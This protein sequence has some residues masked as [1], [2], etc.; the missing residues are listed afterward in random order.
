MQQRNAKLGEAHDIFAM[1]KPELLGKSAGDPNKLPD[2]IRR[3]EEALY[4]SAPSRDDYANVSTLEAR[5][6]EVVRRTGGALPG[7]PVGGAPGAGG[8]QTIPAMQQ[9]Q[10]QQHMTPDGMSAQTIATGQTLPVQPMHAPDN[11]SFVPGDL[12]FMR[13][14]QMGPPQGGA[15]PPGGLPLGPGAP[16]GVA[17]RPMA[18]LPSPPPF[19]GTQPWL[20]VPGAPTRRPQDPGA[21]AQVPGAAPFA[22]PGPVMSNGAPVLLR[23]GGGSSSAPPAGPM[24]TPGNPH[25]FGGNGGV[26]PSYPG[27][28]QQPPPQQQ[29]QQ[30][31]APPPQQQ[32]AQQQPAAH[33]PGLGS[34]G[35]GAPPR[36]G[37]AGPVPGPSFQQQHQFLMHPG[38]PPAPGTFMPLNGAGAPGAMPVPMGGMVP[39]GA[40]PRSGTPG[41]DPGS[42]RPPSAGPSAGAAAGP[43][44]APTPGAPAAQ[45]P[46]SQGAKRPLSDEA[47][48]RSMDVPD[49]PGSMDALLGKVPEGPGSLDPGA[50]DAGVKSEDGARAD[51]RRQ[52]ILK[53]QR[54]LLF[55]RHCA[56]CQLPENE[57]Q[58]GA[59]CTV[60]KA[61][62]H[63]LIHCKDVRCAYP[64]CLPSRELLK[65]HQKC[66]SPE[67]PVCAPVKQYVSRQR[68][69]DFQRRTARMTDAQKAAFVRQ[70]KQQ[71]Q[72]QQQRGAGGAAGTP[73]PGDGPTTSGAT[74][75]RSA[76]GSLVPSELTGPVIHTQVPKRP[77]VYRQENYGTSLLEFMDERLIKTHLSKLRQA[78]AAQAA[79]KGRVFTLDDMPNFEDENSCK[80]CGL[81]RLTFEPP[82]L[83]CFT[84]GQRIKRNQVYYH[85]PGKVEIKGFWCHPCFAE[86]KTEVIQ[87][88]GW[89]VRRAELEKRKNDEEVEE[90]WVQ[91]DLCERW[92][93]QVCG[94]FNKG[95]NEEQRDYHC[96]QCLLLGLQRGERAVPRERPQA[97][98]AAAD[99][100]RCDLSDAIE[101][102]LRRTLGEERAPRAAAQGVDPAQLPAA[103]GLTVRVVN[104]VVKK[105]EV[106]QR[107]LDAFRHEGCPEAFSYRQ[108]VVLLFQT[109][110]GVDLCLY[111]LYVQEYG[112]DAPE[113][114]R[115]TIYLSYLDSVK[116][117]QPEDVAA[118]G[119]GVALRTLV[120]HEVLLGYLAHAKRRATAC[121]SGTWPCCAV[122]RA[123]GIVSYVSNLYDT[124]FEGGSDHRLE[125]P[126]ILHVP[127]FEGDYWPGEA[128]N[129]L[130][131][132]GEEARQA[133]K[134]G[135][136]AGGSRKGSKGKRALAAGADLDVALLA[137][138]GETIGGMREDFI[139]VHLAE[140]CSAC[141]GYI[142]GDVRYAHP[143]PP[144]RVTVK[145]ERT[146]D[147]IALDRPGGEASRTQT[148]N[149]F[150][151][152]PDC[153]AVAAGGAREP[154]DP[155]AP[156]CL[157]GLPAGIE[158][159]A[160]RALPC[161]PIPAGRD[162]DPDVENEFFDTRQAFLSLCQGNHYQ[163]DTLRR[164]KHSSMMV[165]YHLH[166]P[167]APGFAC[168]CNVCQREIAAG[169][170]WRCPVCPDFDMCADCYRRP[171]VS[172][173]HALEPHARKF[174]ETRNRLTEEERRQRAQQLQRT[175]H[176]LVHASACTNAACPSTNCAKIKQ[177]FQHAMHC[178]KKIHGNCQLCWRMWSLLQVH[179][180][181]CTVDNCPVP[182][183]R[184]LR[185][186]SRKQAARREDQRRRAYRA[187]LTNQAVPAAA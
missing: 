74:I 180:K 100:P 48:L 160:L 19:L 15:Y 186:L 30:A 32:L 36:V 110:D 45:P 47:A 68:T 51:V 112:D 156:R 145:S 87:L 9:Q 55:L 26:Y 89:S 88:D 151:L 117:F 183:C 153:H 132:I 159:G 70:L 167:S 57:C 24:I 78:G 3:L 133:G 118:A 61:L 148:L 76:S 131:S 72:Q 64:R 181:Q 106:R 178:P 71:Q 97:M 69:L 25:L 80:V 147:G 128:E 86:M 41:P 93:H 114:N 21:Y 173:P 172:H 107:F 10:Q 2:F 52:Q 40:V 82:S 109:V 115:K 179:A 157:P 152:C 43:G 54:W 95:R 171:D 96:P 166:N 111:C 185:Q 50:P 81:N 120:Y 99:L 33:A 104:N 122:P 58:Y 67:C 11:G 165:L 28:P 16:N 23:G 75:A 73:A 108:K 123:E 1:R 164:A 12:P 38:V 134:K 34:A 101:A 137:R 18:P 126:S 31:A 129:L 94:L 135:G 7:G 142:S 158:L 105:N 98:L 4:K 150:Q 146:F 119:W 124:Y 187:M 29:Q 162:P 169:E 102:R 42:L 17:E 136:P 170:G 141:R 163:F 103:E 8:Q 184:E 79:G 121:V 176:M 125:R 154:A 144:Q 66:S 5:L 53:Q 46:A 77:R 177:L 127:Y 174:D 22:M 139:V 83:Y 130:A 84:C 14:P 49:P 90:G 60:A 27:A 20:G 149:R 161:P 175:M 35:A 62:W 37:S 182:R 155:E 39:S 138:L 91:C 85:T 113:P 116:Y 65:H 6:Q 63:H 59:S 92:V 13:A 140:S 143:S 168:T 44:R 56:K